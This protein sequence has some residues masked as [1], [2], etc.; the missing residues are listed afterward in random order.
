MVAVGGPAVKRPVFYKT[1]MGASFKSLLSD[2]LKNDKYRIIDGDILTG[3]SSGT[4]GF[5]GFYNST[6]SV[7]PIDEHKPFL[8][9]L[10]PGSSKKTYSL[11]NTFLGR[12]KTF[13]FSTKQNGSLRSIVPINAWESVLPMNILPNPLYRS[14]LANDPEE[15]EKLG[16]IECDDEDFALCSFACPSKIDVGAVIRQGLDILEK[17]S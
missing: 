12:N 11:A 7:L 3:R 8:G 2:Q 1:R 16:L 5:I 17:E 6:I 14:I 4:Y 15:M 13:S 9:W 10:Q